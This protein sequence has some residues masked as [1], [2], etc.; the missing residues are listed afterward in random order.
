[1]CVGTPQTFPNQLL[2]T[3]RVDIALDAVAV[4]GTGRVAASRLDIFLK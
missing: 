4:R 3:D 1:M 2:K